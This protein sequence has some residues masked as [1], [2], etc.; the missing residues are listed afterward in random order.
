MLIATEG[1]DYARN[2]G[3]EQRDGIES[4]YKRR[5]GLKANTQGRSRRVYLLFGGKIG[6]IRKE[7]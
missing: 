4:I 7:T 6:R 3:K 5:A 1:K 2:N